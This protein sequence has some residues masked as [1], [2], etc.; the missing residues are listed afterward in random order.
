VPA[1]EPHERTVVDTPLRLDDDALVRSD[2][3]HARIQS[4]HLPGA[5]AADNA[6]ATA[7]AGVDILENRHDVTHRSPPPYIFSI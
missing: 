1:A 3:V 2:L 7:H 4:F 6:A 5:L